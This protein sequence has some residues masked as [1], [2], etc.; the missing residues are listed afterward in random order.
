MLLPPLRCE[1]W[2]NAEVCCRYTN[3]TSFIGRSSASFVCV[4]VFVSCSP[5]LMP[6]TCTTKLSSRVDF[7]SMLEDFIGGLVVQ[8]FTMLRA[9]GS[10]LAQFVYLHHCQSPRF[11]P[12]SSSLLTRS[13][14]QSSTTSQRD[15]PSMCRRQRDRCT[16]VI[17][18]CALNR[19]FHHN[20]Q[21]S[22]AI[23]NNHQSHGRPGGLFGSSKS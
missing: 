8:C 17:V 2:K 3:E 21:Y 22:R 4:V 7:R 11:V 18:T 10:R 23:V 12:L 16:S 13:G 19:L 6:Y 9:R 14:R 15:V 1:C 5:G 20:C